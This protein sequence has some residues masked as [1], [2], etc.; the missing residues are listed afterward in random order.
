SQYNSKISEATCT[1]DATSAK[2]SITPFSDFSNK[3]T[4][5]NVINRSFVANEWQAICLPFDLDGDELKATFGTGVELDEY[6]LLNGTT[7]TFTPQDKL[8]L[9]AG[10]PYLIKPSQAVQNPDFGDVVLSIQ[11]PKTIKLSETDEISFVGTFFK[12]TTGTGTSIISNGAV[13]ENATD[14]VIGISAYIVK[15][16]GTEV[17][18]NILNKEV[19]EL[20]IDMTATDNATT[21]ND[22]LGGTYNITLANRGNLYAD[23]W[24]TICL[25]FTITK[26][27]FEAAIGY[28]TKLCELASIQGSSFNFGKVADKTLKA[29]VPYLI[30]IDNN[31]T[32]ITKDLGTVTFSN[33]KLE[34][35]EGTSVSPKTGYAFV[36]ILQATTLATDGT[37]LFM[38]ANSELYKPSS[39]SGK[40]GGGRAYFKIPS[41]A[42]T[43]GA[44]ISVT[45]DGIVTSIEEQIKNAVEPKDSRVFNLNGQKINSSN[46]Q[47]LPHGIYIINGKKVMK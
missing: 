39:T 19:A 33:T 8:A 29:G 1:I 36:G 9:H 12:T 22:K 5:T 43:S 4:A 32:R 45:I 37:E 17:T 10:V 34:A 44:K 46:L 3:I 16:A 38:G 14:N 26:K 27:N 23:G 31:D 20:S 28:E 2:S 6:T 18:I 7:M 11:Q 35:T 21:M 42:N 40:L 13:A 41:K 25:P 24:C 15:T 47:S 30:M